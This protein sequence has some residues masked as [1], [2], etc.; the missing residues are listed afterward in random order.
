M[1][2][3]Q[4][5]IETYGCQM[6]LAD[7]EVVLSILANSGFT[8]TTNLRTADVVFVNTCAVRENAEQRVFGRLG[9]F[10][11]YKKENPGMLVGVLGCMA[12]RLR[13]DL[14]ESESHV[15]LVVGPDEYR[16]LPELIEGA[17][18]GQRGIAV[19]L[20]RVENYDDILPLRTD[21]ISAWISVMRGCDKFCTFCV[22]PFT[23]GR[24]RS[25]SLESIVKEIEHLS[26]R[27]FKEITL[28]GQN[29]NSYNDG[30]S[31][32]ADLMSA[33]ARVDS[34][35]RIRFTTSHPEDMSDKLIRT[36]AEHENICKYIHLPVQSGSDRILEL[37]NRSYTI[38]HYR[39]VVRKIREV[40]EG[41][42]LST[43]IIAGFP[44]E[45]DDDHRRTMDVLREIGYDGA[46]T[47]KYSP[48]ENTKAWHMGDDI[49][50]EIKLERLNQIIDVQRE[51][52]FQKNQLMIGQ[53][54]EILVEGE[55]TK[56]PDD[57][58][59]RTDANKMVVFP[60]G[61]AET[62]QYLNVKIDRANSATLFGSILEGS[63]FGTDDSRLAANA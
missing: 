22:V 50:E 38:D 52:S 28:L 12:E 46:F 8:Q 60:R 9:D 32:F 14:M 61:R 2:S 21:G 57:F 10:K 40:I 18:T 58:C 63:Q 33:A 5:Y 4:I 34:T 17:L 36:I 3:K 43:D 59:G 45:T 49:S 44:T 26:A 6:N 54:E 47:F 31:D 41:V 25:R 19:R 51:I 30:T 16:R 11:R 42:S 56:S 62:G 29:V 37:M 7:T 1:N 27:G 23:R 24:E 55:S 48:R 13:K 53:V 39:S 35:M 20:S 15:D